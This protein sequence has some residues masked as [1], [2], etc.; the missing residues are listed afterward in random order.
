MDESTEPPDEP[1]LTQH[2]FHGIT[3]NA[4]VMNV[5]LAMQA[6]PAAM[7]HAIRFDPQL[8]EYVLENDERLAAAVLTDGIEELTAIL[9]QANSQEQTFNELEAAS[10]ASPLDPELQ[11]QVE[12]Q[13]R[14]EQ[15][16]NNI[17]QAKSEHPHLLKPVKRGLL[18]V[19]C[20]LNGH[21]VRAFV[22]TGCEFSTVSPTCARECGLEY[23]IDCHASGTING[24]AEATIS[25]K[26]HL[27]QLTL[28]AME[29]ALPVS[30]LVA[31][32][33]L[34]HM[35][36]VLIGLD[37]LMRHEATL[38]LRRQQLCIGESEVPLLL[39]Y[40]PD[41]EELLATSGRSALQ[42]GDEAGA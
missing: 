40:K 22:D 18:F 14:A 20:T 21:P 8:L 12:H 6:D 28:G 17:A 9:Q 42:Q 3:I 39:M 5:P 36:Q 41:G 25:G 24:M 2:S 37:V 29:Q 23:R 33:K 38:D 11:K 30:L 10:E 32:M 31:D 15:V 7:Q 35:K 26:I 4:G 13:I 34:E 16:A 19:D 27:V 1:T